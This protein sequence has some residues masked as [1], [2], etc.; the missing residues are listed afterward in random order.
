[1]IRLFANA[2]LTALSVTELLFWTGT[3]LVLALL[4]WRVRDRK[5]DLP[6]VPLLISNARK[7][8]WRWPTSNYFRLP[9]WRRLAN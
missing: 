5:L 8:S 9:S 7:N 3:F 1:M 2:T 4:L 6:R